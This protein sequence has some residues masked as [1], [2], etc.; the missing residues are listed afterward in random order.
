ML[1]T[2]DALVTNTGYISPITLIQVLIAKSS[3]Q[4]LLEESLSSIIPTWI[5][6]RVWNT[7]LQFWSEVIQIKNV[8]QCCLSRTK[9]LA[10]SLIL[11]GQRPLSLQLSGNQRQKHVVNPAMSLLFISYKFVKGFLAISFLLLFFSSWNFYDVCQRF[12]IQ[13][14]T[15]FQ[16]DPTKNEKFPHRPQL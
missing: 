7:W 13:P 8:Y 6:S 15:Y 2:I 1:L 11:S 12:F 9:W 10:I 4:Q 3:C 5:R 16:V 14:G